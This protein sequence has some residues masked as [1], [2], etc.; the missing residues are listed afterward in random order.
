MKK[1]AKII[2]LSSNLFLLFLCGCQKNQNAEITPTAIREETT[3]LETNEVNVNVNSADVI[4]SEE[5]LE[6]FRIAEEKAKEKNETIKE[7]TKPIV[8]S[9]ESQGYD[10]N[11]L[12]Y[13]S[14][15]KFNTWTTIVPNESAY[16]LAHQ[17][18]LEVAY[19][20][21][22]GELTDDIKEK[23]TGCVIEIEKEKKERYDNALKKGYVFT[24]NSTTGFPNEAP[25]QGE[26]AQVV[27]PNT[28]SEYSYLNAFGKVGWIEST[29]LLKR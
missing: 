22:N 24:Y 26:S 10:K 7:T 3:I 19:S 8:E 9:S 15:E 6:Q 1:L 2:L 17:K 11:G 21:Y 4:F 13:L 25:P 28:G 14:S 29:I 27:N 16:A 12:P 20:C 23:L 5:E 18:R